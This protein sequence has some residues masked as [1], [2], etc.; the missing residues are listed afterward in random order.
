MNTH[1][2]YHTPGALER[3]EQLLININNYKYN[4]YV[5]EL[6]RI[7]QIYYAYRFG[8]YTDKQRVANMISPPLPETSELEIVK[9]QLN[10][11][12]NELSQVKLL[13][14]STQSTLEQTK[15][16]LS[17]VEYELDNNKKELDLMKPDY[18]RYQFI[19]EFEILNK[20][21]QD[22]YDWH[23][24]TSLSNAIYDDPDKAIDLLGNNPAAHYTVMRRTRN[25]IAHAII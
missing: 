21:L 4:S 19:K 10:K 17:K 6:E 9:D 15:N 16:K 24:A 7:N 18:D 12:K 8:L 25:L 23:D 2:L 22:I 3:L 5:Q 1:K 13:L 20:R 11:V 14:S